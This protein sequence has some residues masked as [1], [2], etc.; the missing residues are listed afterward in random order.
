[1]NILNTK[2]LENLVD[3]SNKILNSSEYS[4]EYKK[5]ALDFNAGAQKILILL[6][7]EE[8]SKM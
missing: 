6:L 2:Y 7:K 4:L 8:I 3:E 5:A 1:M